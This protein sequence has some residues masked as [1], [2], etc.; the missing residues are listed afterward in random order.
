MVFEPPPRSGIGHWSRT[1]QARIA[2]TA[3][4]LMA[5]LWWGSNYRSARH[6]EESRAA[7]AELQ[8]LTLLYLD[9]G[10]ARDELRRRANAMAARF[11]ADSPPLPVALTQPTPAKAAVNPP[12]HMVAAAIEPAPQPA[13]ALVPV[14]LGDET[15]VE[16]GPAEQTVEV[17]KGDTL[18]DVLLNAGV[19][20]AQAH[21]AV[22]ALKTVFPARG[23]M[24]GQQI[25]LK[26]NTDET[27]D[28]ESASSAM[29]L[30]GLKLQP[31]VGQDVTLTR[32]LGGGFVAATVSRPLTVATMRGAGSIDSSLF[33]AGQDEG[34][35]VPVMSDVI[36]ALSYDVDFQRDIQPGDQ[37]EIV[38]E[39]YQDA[40]GNFAKPGNVLY[41][42]LR[43]RGKLIEFYRFK[44]KDG[45]ADFYGPDGTSIKKALL[46]TPVDVVHVTSGFGMRRNPILGFSMMHR[47]VDFAAPVGTPIFA[48]GDGAIVR[49]GGYGDYGNYIQ[50]RHNNQFATAYAHLSRFAPGL[51][52][53]ARVHQGQV[54]AYVGTT[55][56][57]TGP[58][59]H[60]EVLR[61]GTQ[62]NPLSNN[63][64]MGDKLQG[65]D[66][67]AFRNARA[68]IDR[69]R[70]TMAGPVLVAS[71]G[72]VNQPATH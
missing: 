24:P 50:I 7:S 3:V 20:Q 39:R 41:A 46:R 15:V 53:G 66:A 69:L 51:S 68:T 28:T 44:P 9:I 19:T 64:P 25:K 17:Q 11:F 59:L 48:A 1:P 38:Y 35:P 29:D 34:V 60:F 8:R 33:E 37:F 42:S 47:G 22:D 26:L 18:L 45:V 21:D 13:A 63:L 52:T 65:K 14:A 61:D 40:E 6:D 62:I 27:A 71:G 57:S 56:R 55:G 2:I 5:L 12:T 36:H 43:L 72:R 58:H 10:S 67:D 31:T 70:Q 30:I 4:M 16:D 32:G 54:I 49:I 23:L